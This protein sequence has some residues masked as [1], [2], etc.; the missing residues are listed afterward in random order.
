VY[1]RVQQLSTVTRHNTVNHSL[2]FVDPITRV[3]TQNVESYWNRVQSRFK[4][5]KGVHKDM[6][7]SYMD[8]F[9]W[10]CNFVSSLFMHGANLPFFITDSGK[11]A[12]KFL[13]SYAI[14]AVSA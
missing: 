2:H 9:K 3:Y 5:M 7:D 12:M 6:L 11:E 14:S 13:P 8:E 10:Q 1:N 4:Q